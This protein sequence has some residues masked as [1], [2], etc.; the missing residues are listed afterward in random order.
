ML[1][2]RFWKKYFKTYDLLNKAIPYQ[3]VLGDIYKSA[4]TQK[5]QKVF[6]AGSGTGNLSL[7][8]KKS[9]ARVISLDFSEEGIKLHKKKD[10]SAEIICGDLTKKLPFEDKNFDCIVSNNVIYTLD[11]KLRK[12]VFL[13]LY[14]ILKK[15]GIIVIS[16]INREFSPT[17]IFKNHLKESLKKYGIIR[18]LMDLLI[19][20]VSVIKMFYYNYLIK[21]ENNQ[22]SFDFMN[23]G[24]Q[25][26]LLLESGFRLRGN[27]K[28]TYAGQAYLDV[29][30]K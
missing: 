27:T 23:D 18:T 22:G 3:E 19:L 28:I 6:D 21:K 9:G 12:K 4:K 20:G 13:E 29:G 2:N 17:V 24:E 8:M 1:D 5:G 7:I 10:P 16:N 14:R 15:G 11:K 30:V 25:R 26:K